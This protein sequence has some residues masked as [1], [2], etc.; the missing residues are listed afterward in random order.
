M[1]LYP[2][3]AGYTD[4]RI[5]DACGPAV[6]TRPGNVSVRVARSHVCDRH[7]RARSAGVDRGWLG[8][9]AFWWA[10][11]FNANIGAWNT[12]SVTTFNWVCAAFPAW[13]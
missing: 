11:E 13:L 10:S 12:A 9:Q 7:M 8:S 5:A 4:E 3:A 1:Y 2:C 6:H